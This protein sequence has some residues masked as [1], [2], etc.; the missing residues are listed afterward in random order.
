VAVSLSGECSDEIFGGYVWYHNP[1]LLNMEGFPW[2]TMMS[3]RERFLKD[4]LLQQMN[5]DEHTRDVYQSYMKEVPK[6][7]GESPV[8]S[9]IREMVYLNMM[10][11][12]QLLLERKDSMSMRTGLEVRV[13]FAD[14]ELVQYVYNIPWS[15]K[16]IDGQAKGILKRAMRGLLPDEI[17]DRIK[18]PFPKIQDPEYVL[19]VAHCLSEAIGKGSPIYQIFDEKKV[20]D[21]IKDAN[22][23]EN[24]N[25]GVGGPGFDY[26]WLLQLHH[27]MTEYEVELVGL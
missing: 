17:V 13:P 21:F 27:W 11:L 22:N 20:I 7:E 3:N 19:S 1:E 2:A 10:N 18:T 25:N 15:M 23:K 12:M 8:E 16:A 5:R 9:R 4:H 24:T 26:G 6:L 14:H